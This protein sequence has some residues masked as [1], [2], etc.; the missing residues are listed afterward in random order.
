MLQTSTCVYGTCMH[1]SIHKYNNGGRWNISRARVFLYNTVIAIMIYEYT[2]MISTHIVHMY[3]TQW[4]ERDWWCQVGFFS[5]AG[6]CVCMY[7]MQGYLI[8]MMGYLDWVCV[9]D[10]TPYF[11]LGYNKSPLAIWLFINTKCFIS[12][13]LD[14]IMVVSLWNLTG[15]GAKEPVKLQSDWKGLNPNLTASRHRWIVR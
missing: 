15:T 12:V 6:R 9:N 1:A 14:D 4:W 2:T 7:F 13:W 5:A 10:Y 3:D 8:H 11:S